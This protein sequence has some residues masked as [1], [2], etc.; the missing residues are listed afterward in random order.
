LSGV[1]VPWIP[2]PK[3]VIEVLFEYVLGV[4]PRDT[5]LDLGCGDGRTVVYAAMRGAR[6]V[7]IEINRVLC[8]IAEISARIGGV[9]DRV[10]II[11]DD[12][13]RVDLRSIDPTLV[14]VY[15]YP[16]VL[17]ELSR[18][19]ENELRPGTIIVSLDFAIRGWSPVF[20]KKLLDEHEHVHAVWIYVVGV[21]NPRARRVAV[22]ERLAELAQRLVWRQISAE[23]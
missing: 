13:F 8:N 18:K 16:S 12:F 1:Q 5:V 9:Q 3:A 20:V 10:K 21:S 14:Y 4:G 23:V 6:G 7:C 15:L 11:C 22:S 2:T 19:F 17:E